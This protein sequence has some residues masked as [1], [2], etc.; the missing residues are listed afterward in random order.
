[1]AAT[2]NKN[3]GLGRISTGLEENSPVISAMPVIVNYLAR[4]AGYTVRMRGK[5]H[6]F[7]FSQKAEANP[8]EYEREEWEDKLLD[9]YQVRSEFERIKKPMEA[10]EF[11][12][13]VGRF[14]PLSDEIS[15]SEFEKWQRLVRLIREREPLARALKVGKKSGEEMQALAAMGGIYDS[16]F[17]D[18]E[19]EVSRPASET[20]A[21]DAAAIQAIGRG[22]ALEREQRRLLRS[23]FGRPPSEAIKIELRPIET[24]RRAIKAANLRERNPIVEMR[25]GGVMWEFLLPPDQLQPVLLVESRFAIQAIASTLYADRISGVRFKKCEGCGVLFRLGKIWWQKYHDERCEDAAKK[26]RD[27][28][29]AKS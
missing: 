1:M 7:V 16:L 4:V 11:L 27:R 12:A 29:E 25:E 8:G 22:R 13:L 10:L 2:G 3:S 23:W 21:L 28:A 17:F 20:A 24:G 15:W 14:S 19:N 26:R 18:E 5:D 6:V 9:A